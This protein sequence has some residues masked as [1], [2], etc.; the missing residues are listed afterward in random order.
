M[1]TSSFVNA[2]YH[3]GVVGIITVIYSIAARKVFKLKPADLGKLYVE[4]SLKLTATVGS[5][6]MTQMWLVTQGILPQKCNESSS[7]IKYDA[8]FF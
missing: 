7:L 2:A 8:K 5:A 3:G 4:D 6:L 1:D